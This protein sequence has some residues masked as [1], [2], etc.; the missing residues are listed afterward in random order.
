[1]LCNICGTDCIVKD[2]RQLKYYRRRR[3]E[4]QNCG[5]RF[6]TIEVKVNDYWGTGR[7][8]KKGDDFKKTNWDRIRAMKPSEFADWL[9][10]TLDCCANNMCDETCPMYECCCKQKSDNI[11][12][13]LNT[14]VSE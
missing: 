10:E 14:E 12:D 6:S 5:V 7:H 8:K 9:A 11:E 4:C 1:M 3:Y 2:S 13:W